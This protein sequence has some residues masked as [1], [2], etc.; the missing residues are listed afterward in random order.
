MAYAANAAPAE[1]SKAVM[2]ALSFE[3]P[4]RP[5]Q[6]PFIRG[7]TVRTSVEES[8]AAD[9]ERPGSGSLHLFGGGIA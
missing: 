4:E 3:G 2:A 5:R 8:L 1:A 9:R 6:P 7:G